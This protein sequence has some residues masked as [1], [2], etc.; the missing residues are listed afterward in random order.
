MKRW[1]A[2]VGGSLLALPLAFAEPQSAGEW[3]KEGETQYNLGDF[4]KA[5][6][7][8]KK[9][10]AL[11]T[12]E[13]KKP[14]YLY[15]IAQ[16]YRQANKCKD[17]VFFYKRFLSLKDQDTVKPL[18]PEKRA[19]I[20]SL[21]TTLEACAKQQEVLANAPPTN[22]TN[23]SEGSGS[24]SGRGSAT[25][26]GTRVANGS[27]DEGDEGDEGV[28]K[29]V[30]GGPKLVSARFAFG[31]SKVSAGSLDVPILPTFALFG[32]YPLPVKL[33]P[34]LEVDVGLALTLTPV[35]YTNTVTNE[36]LTGSFTQ[37]LADAGGVY[38][39]APK[40][41]V[42]GDLG[43]GMLFFG[44]IDHM[45]SPFTAGGA[46]TSGTLAMFALRIAA[47]GE[48]ELSPT[49]LATFTPAF[50]YSPPKS[51]LRDDI[52]SLTRLDV[53]VGVGYRM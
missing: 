3:Y 42:R 50:T 18:A 26:S 17:S 43:L 14:A 30:T 33:N 51:G 7:A 31:A 47:S 38:T 48:Y 9:G 16:A 35:P 15:N 24:G 53:M 41:D 32:G 12:V 2:I 34:K 1:M 49:V 37:V 36:K 28:T 19:E 4:D 45:G 5:A 21:I 52:K 39:V 20:E 40:I 25:G 22:I 44:G 27:G 13:T 46:G 11:E 10:Y 8:F 23:P 6:E 29:K